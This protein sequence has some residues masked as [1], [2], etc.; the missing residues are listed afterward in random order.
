MQAEALAN[1]DYM[2]IRKESTKGTIAGVPNVYVPL[3]K[4]SLHTN[5]NLQDDN[6]IVGLKHKR[7]QSLP[8]Y[9]SHVG[10]ALVMGEPNTA[11]YFFD[12]LMTK[13]NTSGSD[14]YTHPFT[15][16]TTADPHSY[17]V[18]VKRGR[19]V[20]RYLGVEASSIKPEWDGNKMQLDVAMSALHS[21]EGREI[22]SIS[23]SGPYTI[24][25]KTNYD[26]DA[27]TGLY[28]G[29][30]IQIYDVSANSYINAVVDTIE[31]VTSITVSEDVSAA[32]AG[33]FVTLRAS[34]PSYSLLSPFL[35]TRSEFR[36]GADASTAL[37]ATQ[38]QLEDSSSWNIMHDFENNEGAQ[39]SG[40]AD[41]ASLPRLQSDA[42]FTAKKFWGNPLDQRRFNA[43]EKNA[44]VIRHFS[45][46]G[47]ELRITLNNIKTAE[48][49]Q[50]N[51]ESGT[52]DYSE[53]TF[54]PDYDSS[55]GQAVGVSVLNSVSSI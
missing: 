38:T 30:L 22:A 43:L 12:M 51:V 33:D 54:K 53:I 40:S 28:V 32:T 8:G 45:G 46:S 50:P 4:E 48:N 42:E 17:T 3:Y 21:W 13:G 41:P 55:D 35:R 52:I 34:T 18:D 19:H 29:D 6:P 24:V 5:S 27:T 44:V 16:S 11:G 49:V 36:F 37:S 20:A 14:P 23:G 15:F 9:R 26:A 10:N 39:R 1:L 25:F 7:Y 2:A 31:N 47:Y